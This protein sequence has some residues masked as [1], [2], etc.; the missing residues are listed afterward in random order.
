MKKLFIILIAILLFFLSAF[1]FAGG[2]FDHS[3]EPDNDLK[4]FHRLIHHNVESY[5]ICV[6]EIE[7]IEQRVGYKDQI[8]IKSTITFTIKGKKRI[9]ERLIF[10]RIK[11][12]KFGDISHMKGRLYF[13]FLHSMGSG[14]ISVDPQDPAALIKYKEEYNK[15][16]NDHTYNG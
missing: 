11:D 8:I 4:D 5:I 2:D 15:V 16:A 7:K 9:G 14:D 12:G 13:V 10:N 1:S 6:Y 3:A